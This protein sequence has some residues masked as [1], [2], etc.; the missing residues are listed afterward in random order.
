MWQAIY[1]TL[2]S[3]SVCLAQAASSMSCRTG[4]AC[5]LTCAGQVHLLQLACQQS[6]AHDPHCSACSIALSVLKW[7]LRAKQAV[8]CASCMLLCMLRQLSKAQHVIHEA[9]RM[10]SQPYLHT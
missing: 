6:D 9:G 2:L 4:R 8:Q 5:Q 3:Q 10:C 1:M 7:S